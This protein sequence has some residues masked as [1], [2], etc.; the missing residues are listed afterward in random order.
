MAEPRWL[1][2]AE[3]QAWRG[4]HQ[5][6]RALDHALSRRLGDDSGLSM[7]DYELLVPLSEA[8][9]RRLRARDLGH[10][11]QWEKSRLSKHV[12]RME[13]RGL[14]SRQ[15]C[16][17]DA[18]GSFICLTEAGWVAIAAAAPDHVEAVRQ[19]FLDLLDAE[20]LRMFREVSERVVERA[21][22]TSGRRD[23]CD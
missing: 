14:V 9:D 11:V 8:T 22:E 16:S 15:E 7:A 18:R 1:T 13:Q 23:P 12:S 2:E 21:A 20:Q 17:S 3:D 19:Y 10:L 4:L 5:M 6:N